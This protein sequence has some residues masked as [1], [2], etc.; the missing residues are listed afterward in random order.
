[1][2]E[3]DIKRFF[4]FKRQLTDL[5]KG[6][7]DPSLFFLGQE[8]SDELEKRSNK[9][10][11]QLIGIIKK[12]TASSTAQVHLS[13][14]LAIVAACEM[15]LV[16]G[17]GP[18]GLTFVECYAT[19]GLLML[20]VAGDFKDEMVEN[21]NTNSAQIY[22][23]L[24]EHLMWNYR[25]FKLAKMMSMIPKIAEKIAEKI[26]PPSLHGIFLKVRELGGKSK[27]REKAMMA[28]QAKKV[29]SD[30]LKNEVL[31]R[32]AEQ[33]SIGR[34]KFGKWNSPLEAS[35]DLYHTMVEPTKRVKKR[36]GQEDTRWRTTYEWL[37][38]F[39]KTRNSSC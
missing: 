34:L 4:N 7:S 8:F 6:L 11:V 9:E 3:L 28:V 23:G 36:D 15:C 35:K 16:E 29:K 1:M 17:L 22:R 26:V 32:Y 38:E 25:L 37:L 5:G 21:I 27:L 12:T 19:S 30:L 20:R 2:A 39:E 33:R 18:E 10:L 13:P 24:L 14:A 31:A